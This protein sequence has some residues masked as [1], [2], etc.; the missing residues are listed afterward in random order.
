MRYKKI[1]VSGK[2]QGVGFREFLRK[3]ASKIGS[4]IGY[5]KNLK[6]G[7]L[8]IIFA[9]EPEKT[10]QFEKKCR[11]GPLLASIKEVSEEEV[12]SEDEFDCFVIRY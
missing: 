9:G 3:E 2:V 5:A 6:N 7:S 11:S 4:I 12:D 8:E 10:R 1:T